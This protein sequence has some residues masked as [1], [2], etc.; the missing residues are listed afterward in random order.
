MAL[1]GIPLVI[2]AL[3]AFSAFAKDNLRH[4]YAKPIK[5]WPTAETA[6][7]QPATALAPLKPKA[8]LATAQQ[9]A[10]GKMLFNDPLL[11]RDNSVSCASCH[12]S[13]RD[14]QDGRRSAIG[15]R[16]QEGKRNTP[17]IFGIDHWES[18]FWDG[19]AQSAT[20]QAL[21]PIENPIEMDLPIADALKRLN[22]SEV[23]P[24]LFKNAY[25]REDITPPML[26]M[27]LVAF[28]RTIPPPNSKYQ[29][30]ITLAET[31]PKKAANMLSDSELQGLH[32]FRTKAQCMT[33][34][35]G[36]LLSDNEFHVTGFHLYGRR[37]EDLGRSE[38]TQDAKDIG[39]FR[40]PSLLGVSNTGPWMHN[41]LFTQFR[42][43]IMQY[44][45]GGFR[46]KA[47]GSKASD[48][49]FPETTSLIQP[50]NLTEEEVTALVEFLNIL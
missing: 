30:F 40:T 44:N 27:A 8:P 35:E 12:L 36:A 13:E 32:L 9:I 6:D 34:H 37:F 31:S 50:L 45:A 1:R 11:S 38:F 48:P 15:V 39:K 10:L 28:E 46:P 43:M 20:E 3:L 5:N 33:C 41:G 22:E 4:M 23:F 18:F 7:G 49:F 29:Q 21:K 26:A 2:C 16:E 19:R 17:P 24:S 47:R 42:P 14:F 25:G